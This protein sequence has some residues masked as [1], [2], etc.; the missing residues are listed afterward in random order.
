MNLYVRKHENQKIPF[1]INSNFII[2]ISDIHNKHK[3]Q[4]VNCLVILI[5]FI[6]ICSF[7]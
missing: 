3:F 5:T 4:L 7:S 6:L 2:L 1:Q